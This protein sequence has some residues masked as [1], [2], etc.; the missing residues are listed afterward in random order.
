MTHRRYQK[1]SAIS[2]AI[3]RPR[4]EHPDNPRLANLLDDHG[5]YRFG[6]LRCRVCL[7]HVVATEAESA[8]LHA[9]PFFEVTMLVSG[10]L[11]FTL[12]TGG[13]AR[14]AS[15]DIFIMPPNQVH[16]WQCTDQALLF[17]LM[18]EIASDEHVPALVA[19]RLAD[20]CASRRYRI[21]ADERLT[22][23]LWQLRAQIDRPTADLLAVDDAY[24]RLLCAL[25]LQ[26]LRLDLSTLAR[27][28]SHADPASL[29]LDFL[30]RYLAEDLAV[31]D[32]ATHVGVG[33]RQLNRLFAQAGLDSV[34]IELQNLRMRH[35]QGLLAEQGLPIGQVAQLCGYRD[36]SYFARVFRQHAGM[37]PRRFR[38]HCARSLI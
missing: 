12:P 31:D 37:S 32:V 5:D 23:C 1:N 8:P 24:L 34:Q 29:A 20:A 7:A 38:N 22:T 36:A 4:R 25:L 11:C 17:G 13:R 3:P 2:R 15:G 21:T 35:A 10:E 27:Q 26:E 30:A 28:E 9:H 19:R 14:Y 33:T 18:L 6:E 16:G